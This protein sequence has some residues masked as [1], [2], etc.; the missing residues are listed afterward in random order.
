MSYVERVI[1]VDLYPLMEKYP[2]LIK[3]KTG[4]G[5]E[6]ITLDK[7][8]KDE[9]KIEDIGISKDTLM[10]Q[11]K[12]ALENGRDQLAENFVRASELI[13]IPDKEILEMYNLLRPYRATE[14]QLLEIAQTLEETYKAPLCSAFVKETLEVYKKRDILL[15]E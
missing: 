7:V 5:L 4:K 11:A 2:E 10:L 14:S 9:I 6:D 1:P 3:S 8:M 15:K 13:E 12:V